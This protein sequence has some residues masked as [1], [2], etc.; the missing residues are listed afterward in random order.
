[1]TVVS[2]DVAFVNVRANFSVAFVSGIASASVAA[3]VVSTSC[4]HVAFIGG[5]T[6]VDVSTVAWSGRGIV[7]SCV[8]VSNLTS[9]EEAS[10]IVFA[11]SIG[12]T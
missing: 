7:S 2:I 5:K 4:V 3:V 12:V 8:G 10:D 6:F 11:S 9:T 1:M